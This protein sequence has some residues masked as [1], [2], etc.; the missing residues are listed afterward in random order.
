MGAALPLWRR[1]LAL[2]VFL[3]AL[4]LPLNAQESDEGLLARTLQGFLSDAGR[5]VRITGFEGALSSRATI[6]ELSISD[7]EGV[8]LILEGVALDWR[9]A[10]LLDRRVEVN[11]LSA[12]EIRVLRLPGTDDTGLPSP[13]ARPEFRLPELPVAVQIGQLRADRV[14][15]EAPVTGQRTE[16]WLAGQ[17]SLEGG[18]GRAQFRSERSDGQFGRFVFDGSFDNATRQLAIDLDL[19]EGP[20]GIAASALNIADRPALA[21]TVRGEGPLESFRAE[22]GM[23]SNGTSRI[24]GE[25]QIGAGDDG[26]GLE[27]DLAGDLRPLMT[28]ELHGFF[29]SETRMRALAAYGDDGSIRLNAL[30]FVTGAMQLVGRVYLDPQARPQVVDLLANIARVD[31]LPVPLPGTGGEVTITSAQLEIEYDLDLSPDW[32]VS[33]DLQGLSLPQASVAR[34]A[35]DARGRL[36]PPTVDAGAQDPFSG[37]FDFV[38]DGIDSSNPALAQA[39]GRSMAGFASIGWPGPGEPLEIEGLVLEG[40]TLG[41]SARGTMEGARFTGFT[42]AEAFDLA[43]FSGIAGRNLGGQLLFVSEGEVNF[44]TGALALKLGLTG[45]DMTIDQRE[46]DL[47]LSGESRM[48]V[49]IVR[50]TEGTQLRGLR[51]WAG[52]LALDAE[53]RFTEEGLHLVAEAGIPDLSLLGEGFGGQVALA[54]QLDSGGGLDLLSVDGRALDLAPGDLPGAAVVRA[55]MEGESRFLMRA[56]RS[57]GTI[58]LEQLSFEAPRLAF[59]AQGNLPEAGTEGT[60]L[61]MVLARLD[62]AGFASDARGVLSGRAT[63][64]GEGEG[65]RRLRVDLGSAAGGLRF[66]VR[67]LDSLL[68]GDLRVSADIL[69]GGAGVLDIARAQLRTGAVDVSVSGRQGNDGAGDFT[70]TGRLDS[71]ARVMPGMSGALR[72]DGRAN[73]P[74]G[75]GPYALRLTMDGPSELS[76]RAEGTMTPDFRLAL[77]LDATVEAGLIN[78]VIDP[79]SMQGRM[80]FQG[81]IDGAPGLEALSGAI[82]LAEGRFVSPLVGLAFEGISAR[83]ELQGQTLRLDAQARGQLG[84]VAR[85]AGTIGVLGGHPANLEVSAEALRIASAPILEATI[86]GSAQLTGLLARNPVLRGSVAVDQAE[87]RIPNSPLGRYG[88]IPEGMR[89]I[90]ERG[91]SARTRARAGVVTGERG[92][93]AQAPILLDLALRAPGRVFVRGRGLDA[94]LGGTLRLSGST[95]DVIPSGSFSLVRGRLDLLGNR[96]VLTEGSASLVGDFVP[97]VT[98][99]ATTESAGALTSVILEGEATNPQ[100]RF[101]SVPE[102]PQDEV[103]ARLVFRRSLTSLSPFQAAQLGLS[104]ATL[105]GRADNSVLSRARSGLGLDDLDFTTDDAGVTALRVG[106][107]IN[108]QVYTDL[109]VDSAGRGEVSINLDLTP[110]LTLRGRTGSDG[111]SAVGIFFERDY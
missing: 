30:S 1:P 102:L 44:F 17:V 39:L 26:L 15:L 57:D 84:G 70:L 37:V 47:F 25:V 52:G 58:R 81:R 6:R 72:L 33:A 68:Q 61:E 95:R 97:Y 79:M 2:L 76:A 100:I 45:R 98:L 75:D 3:F 96:F 69:D 55:L 7:A 104:V 11:E 90:G 65:G 94:E 109:R 35:L 32:V 13:A 88:Y 73:R 108:E 23:E 111:R 92:A 80:R 56:Q 31:G 77:A 67:L 27:L 10:A 50:N 93:S 12:R 62:A 89:H 82:T 8:W 21:L 86:T 63:L 78:P 101:E 54:L 48:G 59:R 36:M 9:R 18:E 38:A 74:A 85:V 22:I 99:T 66:G 40:E 106:R 107:Y 87:V 20:G 28:P 91:E 53:G 49:D 34:M 110:S 16:M 43:A 51:L 46:A 14:V 60:D 41:L 103:L 105:T 19:A 71:L 29:G 24:A 64:Q 5:E 4:A 42:E 83:G